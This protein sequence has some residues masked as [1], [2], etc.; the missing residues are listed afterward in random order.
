MKYETS[1]NELILREQIYNAIR[2]KEIVRDK[3]VHV[4]KIKMMSATKL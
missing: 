2:A 4:I 1:K 3:W